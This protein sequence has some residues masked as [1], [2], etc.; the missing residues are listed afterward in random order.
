[1]S[2][3]E[4]LCL[5]NPETPNSSPGDPHINEEQSQTSSGS[6]PRAGQRQTHTRQHSGRTL[7]PD[8]CLAALGALPGAVALGLLSTARANSMRGAYAEILRWH[9]QARVQRDE[10]G[11]TD[12]AVLALARSNPEVLS[13]L[14]P[15]LT[16][17]QIELVTGGAKEPTD[18]GQ[19]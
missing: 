1:M 16:D 15:F 18:D 11:L 17:A 4:P 5:P 6:N 10:G 2:D 8:E 9:G 3:D 13:M 12:D 19:A 7:S 14:E